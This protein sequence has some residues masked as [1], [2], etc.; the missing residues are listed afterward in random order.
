M[1]IYRNYIFPQATNIV[2][3]KSGVLYFSCEHEYHPTSIDINDELAP[4]PIKA[5]GTCDNWS[6]KN[7]YAK[8]GG[9]PQVCFNCFHSVAMFLSDNDLK[10]GK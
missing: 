3:Y 8:Y 4:C 7:D 9:Y 2:D 5:T 6:S 1:G 10:E